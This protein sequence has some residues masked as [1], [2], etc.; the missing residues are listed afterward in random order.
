MATKK[1]PAKKSKKPAE[2]LKDKISRVYG[3]TV[4]TMNGVDDKTAKSLIEDHGFR[5]GQRGE[6]GATLFA[7][8]T[9][10]DSWKG[11]AK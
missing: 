2:K 5:L 1:A 6:G 7:D 9:A 3:A 4:F 10:V 11:A 8:K